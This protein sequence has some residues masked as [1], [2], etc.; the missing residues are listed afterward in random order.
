MSEKYY[1]LKLKRDFFKRHDIR[2]VEA[3]PNGKDYILFYLKL[4]CESVD[5][6]GRLRFS[7]RIPYNDDMLATITNTNIDIVRRAIEIFAELG[8]MEMLDDGTLFMT[9]VNKMLGSASNNP[10]ALRQAR[11]RERQKEVELLPTVTKSNACVTVDVTEDNESKSKNKSKIK[12]KSKSKNIVSNDTIDRIWNAFNDVCVS[13]PR[14]TRLTE[15]RRQKI[16]AR[17]GTFTE[18]EVIHAFH[19]TEESDFLT[20]R[21]GK[22]EKGASFDWIVDSDAHMLKILEGN[23]DNK[24][25]DKYEVAM[26]KIDSMFGGEV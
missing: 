21:S 7:D 12:S 22:W 3:M 17:L 5:H 6:D 14:A 24:G 11:F 13:L 16:K 4:L 20:G 19:K 10:N 25:A 2:I 18:D 1:W 26:R 23:Y 15:N 8:M 9:E